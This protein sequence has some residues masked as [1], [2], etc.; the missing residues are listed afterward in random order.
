M[1]EWLRTTG[2]HEID[3]GV[4]SRL[5]DCLKH[6]AEIGQW[7]KTLPANKRQQLAHPNAVWRAW[8]KST[9]S[10]RAIVTARPSPTA[11]YKDEI[12]RLENENHVLRR[13]GDDLFTA[14]DTAI[15]I[16]RLLADRLLRVTPSKARQIL[17]L[18]PELYAERLAETPHDKA[19]PRTRTK[20]RT[21]E[22]FQ[23]DL[24]ARKADAGTN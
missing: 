22:D 18:L 12:A 11:M 21:A 2:F 5:L 15:D 14:I 10:G 6:R 3:K 20:R 8:R 24:A 4:R 7:H 19:R 13:A 23:R 17:E 16:A 1:G 9:L